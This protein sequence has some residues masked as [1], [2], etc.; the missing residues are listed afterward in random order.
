[1]GRFIWKRAEICL[2]GQIGKPA[3]TDYLHTELLIKALYWQDDYLIPDRVQVL[4]YDFT[5]VQRLPVQLK[6]HV[7]IAGA[8]KRGRERARQVFIFSLK[9]M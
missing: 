8:F 3:V 2:G 5:F 1:M 6:F 7:G 4:V 9:C